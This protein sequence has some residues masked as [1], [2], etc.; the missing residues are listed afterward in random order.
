MKRFVVAMVSA[1]LV[2]SSWSN[3]ANAQT[4]DAIAKRGKVIVAVD[5]STPP[6]GMLDEKMA[7]VGLDVDMAKLIAADLGVK[8]EITQVSGPN[9][10]PYL[11]S[12]KVDFVV[13]TFGVTAERAKTINFSI[14]YASNQNTVF[15][16]P[17]ATVKSMFDL[18]GKSIAVVRGSTQDL[19]VT[20]RA[21]PNTTIRR[22]EDDA[23]ASNA[24]L[25]GQV[26]LIITSE[27][28]GQSLI[29]KTGTTVLD[30]KFVAS[31]SP[32]SIGLRKG[33][34]EFLQFL[35][36]AIYTHR[37][38]GD[39]KALNAKWVKGDLPELPSF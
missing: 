16:R 25:A 29:A 21:P 5:T 15:G 35:N 32:Y 11:L 13:A 12:N 4:L 24:M 19:I 1:I 9:R 2:L 3:L 17:T 33:D 28:I 23:A 27:Q 14:P 34:W 18:A 10:I 30:K 6:Y 7:P 26:D 22:F 37:N 31:I 36:T 39:L 20:Q 38:N 8:L